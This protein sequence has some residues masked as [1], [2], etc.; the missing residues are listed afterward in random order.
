[1]LLRTAETMPADIGSVTCSVD[2]TRAS[3]LSC[4]VV[5]MLTSRKTMA[6]SCRRRLTTWPLVRC[7]LLLNFAPPAKINLAKRG[8]RV[9]ICHGGYSGCYNGRSPGPNAAAWVSGRP[10]ICRTNHEVRHLIAWNATPAKQYGTSV[11]RRSQYRWRTPKEGI[12]IM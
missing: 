7:G 6:L 5:A 12:D 1:M 2:M 11:W 9:F 10:A 4:C 8:T 3:A